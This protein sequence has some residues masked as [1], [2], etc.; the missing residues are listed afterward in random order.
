MIILGISE[1]MH[2][3]AACV[4]KNG[5]ILSA[6]PSERLTKVKKD[7]SLP[8]KVIKHAL[9]QAG[10]TLEDVDIVVCATCGHDT[11]DYTK[12]KVDEPLFKS[13]TFTLPGD[14]PVRGYYIPHHICHAAQ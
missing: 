12:F 9:L 2:D 1:N 4:V 5:R 13:R 10:I 14:V 7:A 3:A 8:E 11:D 6:I